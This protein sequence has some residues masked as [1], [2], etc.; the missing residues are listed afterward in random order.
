VFWNESA[1]KAVLLKTGIAGW[2]SGNIFAGGKNVSRDGPPQAQKT[3]H[4][5]SDTKSGFAPTRI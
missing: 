1:T 2:F 3:T 5:W 4:R